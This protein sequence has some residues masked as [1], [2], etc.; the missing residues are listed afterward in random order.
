VDYSA[1]KS[2]PLKTIK[3]K[4]NL[5]DD[6]VEV[7]LDLTNITIEEFKKIC[8]REFDYVNID[9]DLMEL[10]KIRKLPN[11]LIRNTNDVRRLKDD[12]S[13]EFCFVNKNKT[14]LI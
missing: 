6:F 5:D 3:I 8:I 2:A 14:D 10:D 13:V 4:T 11:I 1:A 9:Y 7:D 12:Q